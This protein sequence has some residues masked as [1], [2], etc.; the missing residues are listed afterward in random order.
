MWHRF[1]AQRVCRVYCWL[2]RL[3]WKGFLLVFYSLL[4][5]P[6]FRFRLSPISSGVVDE[7]PRCGIATT[8]PLFVLTTNVFTCYLTSCTWYSCHYSIITFFTCTF[9]GIK[10][11]LCAFAG[12]WG[13]SFF[14]HRACARQ[15]VTMSPRSAGS[16]SMHRGGLEDSFFLH[17]ELVDLKVKVLGV[18]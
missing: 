5:S 6:V 15:A 11:C 9:W 7:E 14:K 4:Y 16:S 10:I 17:K 8:K 18:F 3:H 12:K 13:M 2:S 1:E